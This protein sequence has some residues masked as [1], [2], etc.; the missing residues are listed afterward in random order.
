MVNE[1]SLILTDKIAQ[2]AEDVDI[3][4]VWGTGFPAY[5]GGLLQYADHRGLDNIVKRLNELHSK[6][7][8]DYF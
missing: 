7:S 8:H 5:R 2:S 4:M 1:A 6:T 3:G